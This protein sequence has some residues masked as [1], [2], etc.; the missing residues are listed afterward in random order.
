M[1][2]KIS[3]ISHSGIRIS[4]KIK[5]HVS[6][7]INRRSVVD[8]FLFNLHAIPKLTLRSR[9]VGSYGG[10]QNSSNRDPRRSAIGLH[11]PAPGDSENVPIN[12]ERDAERRDGR[13][14]R[15][16][17]E[18]GRREVPVL[19]RRH[20]EPLTERLRQSRE[21]IPGVNRCV[22]AGLSFASSKKKKEKKEK[23][24]KK[25]NNRE[26]NY[27]SSPRSSFSTRIDRF[28]DIVLYAPIMRIWRRIH[29]SFFFSF[30][31]KY[32]FLARSSP[33]VRFL[34]TR[35]FHWIFEH[36][37]DWITERSK[38]RKNGQIQGIYVGLDS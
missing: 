14:R 33:S 17:R 16:T 35:Y 29:S 34:W 2:L 18:V 31:L 21:D 26:F 37:I 6:L 19:R 24:R 23:K 38:T 27:L 20:E 10:Y 28:A 13:R 8:Q 30:C 7:I 32:L 12:R 9:S 36:R 15:R 5:V 11:W 3:P 22:E 25:N 1:I 4:F